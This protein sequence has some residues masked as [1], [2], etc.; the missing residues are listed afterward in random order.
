VPE[1]SQVRFIMTAV[2]SLD[3]KQFND[4]YGRHGS[5]AY[6]PFMMLTLL[7]YG[8]VTGV[9]S[10][11]K[12]EA[13]TYD[14]I[15][16]RFIAGNTHP[17][18]VTIA[19]FRRRFLSQFKDVFRQVLLIAHQMEFVSL[20][21]VAVDGSKLK[22]NASRHAALS[23][24]H[25]DKLEA[26]FTREV[27][28]L[29]LE[30][31][32]ADNDRVITTD[33][34]TKD[35][36]LRRDWL[37]EIAQAKAEITAR[38]AARYP[39]EKAAYDIELAAYEARQAKREARERVEAEKHAAWDAAHPENA[40]KREARR[41]AKVI[42][43]AVKRAASPAGAE[44]P[45][46]AKRPRNPP[47]APV[48]GPRPTDQVNLTDPES[49]IMP[50]P[51][52]GFVQAYNIQIAVTTGSMLVVALDVTQ[53]TN[54]KKQVAPMLVHLAQI[55]PELGVPTAFLG[56]AGFHSAENIDLC[57]SAGIAP[58]I[59]AKREPHHPDVLDRYS[60]PEP[61]AEGASAV[62]KA[63]HYLKTKAG[64][65]VF[66]LRKQT[67]EPVFGIIKSVMGFRQFSM[68]GLA[69]AKGELAL[70]CLAWNFKRMGVLRL[71]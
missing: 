10:S 53:D 64:R 20:G 52:G 7:I 30:G 62:E 12:I 16:M 54:D 32:K 66:A 21:Q 43:L 47:V 59:V 13:A 45:A 26:R 71:Q 68:R 14:S 5:P 24:A 3:L 1:G 34:L 56:D 33:E 38:A 31:E 49:R 48:P 35:I 69:A 22:A 25:A 36:D 11:R 51:T 46:P 19:E 17:C 67:V 18:Y 44:A 61:L 41:A 2:A 65:A 58:V 28:M 60:E 15:A 29:I 23:Y 70:V 50:S 57:N 40:A 39:D 63:A 37:A 9:F 6:P 4:A 42:E 27:E 8:Y 55:P